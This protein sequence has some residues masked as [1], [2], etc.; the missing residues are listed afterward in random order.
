M[1]SSGEFFLLRR[2]SGLT[3]R[4]LLYLQHRIT[5][6]EKSLSELDEQSKWEPDGYAGIDTIDHDTQPARQKLIDDAL[7]VLQRYCQRS[8][9]GQRVRA[10]LTYSMQ[11]T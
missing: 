5:K 7:P 4:S 10:S 11:T 3:A 8:T 6:I 2:Y 9:N 1:A